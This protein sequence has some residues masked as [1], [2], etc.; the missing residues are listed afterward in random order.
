M[1]NISLSFICSLRWIGYACVPM[2]C[3]ASPKPI[4]TV[5]LMALLAL[6][7]LLAP[8]EFAAFAAFSFVRLSMHWHVRVFAYS[9]TLYAFFCVP[10]TAP[11]PW[12]ELCGGIMVDAMGPGLCQAT[13]P[14]HSAPEHKVWHW[15]HGGTSAAPEQ[16]LMAGL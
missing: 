4:G 12:G 16:C 5:D 8:P 11:Y 6:L 14:H 10:G 9:A 13:Q 3:S 1:G 2:A 15:F 7:A